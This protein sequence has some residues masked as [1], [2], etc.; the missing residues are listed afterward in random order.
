VDQRRVLAIARRL[1]A[2][3]DAAAI[4]LDAPPLTSSFAD[5]AA[6]HAKLSGLAPPGAQT[7][8][9]PTQPFDVGQ[10]PRHLSQPLFAAHAREPRIHIILFLRGGLRLAEGAI[11]E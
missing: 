9:K 8:A 5:L 3:A 4:R 7:L 6:E 1:V 10:Q 2:F 11:E